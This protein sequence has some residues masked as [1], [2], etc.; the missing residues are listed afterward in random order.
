MHNRSS[1]PLHRA[2]ED[3]DHSTLQALLKQGHPVGE[4]SECPPCWRPLHYACYLG[5]KEM[6]AMLLD[7][8]ADIHTTD[9]NGRTALFIATQYNQIDIMHL[10]IQYGASPNECHMDYTYLIHIAAKNHDT[11][12]LSLLIQYNHYI[13]HK[14]ERHLGDTPLYTAIKS[15]NTNA[16]RILI[17]QGASVTQ[18]HYYMC[19]LHAASYA[20][21][22]TA[23]AL[24]LDHGANLEVPTEGGSTALDI[25]LHHQKI[26]AAVMLIS[27]GA[28]SK[29][30]IASEVQQYPIHA[31]IQ[32]HMH[33]LIPALIRR[34]YAINSQNSHGATPLDLAI[35][36]PYSLAYPMLRE[37]DAQPNI[38]HKSTAALLLEAI[39]A[40]N[41]TR[42]NYL[43]QRIAQPAFTY[44]GQPNNT[45]RYIHYLQAQ[46]TIAANKIFIY[47]QIRPTHF[48][49]H[50]TLLRQIANSMI[51][52][53]ASILPM[54]LLN[55][56]LYLADLIPA[57]INILFL[58]PSAWIQ[59]QAI[60][61]PPPPPCPVTAPSK[62][63]RLEEVI[64]SDAYTGSPHP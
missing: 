4:K 45:A 53:T 25:A 63:Q 10:L 57:H 21:Q 56:I 46:D 15:G 30:G 27:A 64:R 48:S 47:R 55:Y 26:H 49:R 51:K 11:S 20:N 61:S 3:G 52:N 43:F 54:D 7:A 22:P 44:Q 5:E 39:A 12:A 62:P 35:A 24:L 59:P 2:I 1:L 40:D 37:L 13:I 29:N 23:I 34:G 42:A 32:C 14:Q 17:Q 60:L 28:E 8:K 58:L 31:A 38:H 41:M 50:I 6:V 16:M 9:I 18:R 33:T 36:D 19:P